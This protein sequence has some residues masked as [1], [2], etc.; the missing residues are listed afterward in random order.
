[1]LT[2]ETSRGLLDQ[3]A[4]IRQFVSEQKIYHEDLTLTV[5]A[6]AGLSVV[7]PGD[8]L[9]VAYERSDEGLYQAKK[10]GRNRGCW[11]SDSGWEPFPEAVQ[12][13]RPGRTAVEVRP[14]ADEPDLKPAART[15][16]SGEAPEAAMALVAE[17]ALPALLDLTTFAARI[18]KHLANLNARGLPAGCFMVELISHGSDELTQL[19]WQKT[20][21][22]H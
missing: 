12:T 18:A 13:A 19:C 10:S 16:A 1:M 3:A 7:Q 14:V 17:P 20:I 6:S 15:E 5:T 8:D 11:L 4:R 9:K 22:A 21:A 2:A